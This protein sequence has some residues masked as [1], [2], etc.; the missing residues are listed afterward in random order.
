MGVRLKANGTIDADPDERILGLTPDSIASTSFRQPPNTALSQMSRSVARKGKELMVNGCAAGNER[1][2]AVRLGLRQE[3]TP[4]GVAGRFDLTPSKQYPRLWFSG[5]PVGPG[6]LINSS[7]FSE[8]TSGTAQCSRPTLSCA[9]QMHIQSPH[10]W[11][12]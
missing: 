9:A 4:G 5:Y 7:S 3:I 8:C 6:Y 12:D 1:E 11:T 2:D 10:L